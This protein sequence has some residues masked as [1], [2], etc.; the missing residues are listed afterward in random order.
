MACYILEIQHREGHL[1]PST[2][3]CLTTCK[4]KT[5]A[6]LDIDHIPVYTYPI[7]LSVSTLSK[8]GTIFQD[9]KQVVILSLA[10]HKT[11]TVLVTYTLSSLNLQLNGSTAPIILS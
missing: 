8:V 3:R 6:T 1:H 5:F 7:K 10:N 4:S 11:C 2:S 9:Q